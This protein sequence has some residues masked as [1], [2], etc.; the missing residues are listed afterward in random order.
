MRVP[1]Q[2]LELGTP[3]PAATAGTARPA[4]RVV[5]SGR[6]ATGCRTPS[7]LGELRRD[8]AARTRGGSVYRPPVSVPFALTLTK[9]QY[10]DP[11]YVLSRQVWRLLAGPGLH[12][13][14]ETMEVAFDDDVRGHRAPGD[15]AKT[16]RTRHWGVSRSRN[17]RAAS[18]GR[19]CRCVGAE[20]RHRG[21]ALRREMK[22]EMRGFVHVLE[23]AGSAGLEIHKATGLDLAR[24]DLEQR[25]TYVDAAGIVSWLLLPDREAHAFLDID[26]CARD[27][28]GDIDSRGRVR[29]R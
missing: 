29:A 23:R 8:T 5:R 10:T 1:G 16:P 7:G 20:R 17:R 26:P 28:F 9:F 6:P 21:I 3:V 15:V 22:D 11:A 19:A 18:M 12:R 27:R 25:K 2:E 14:A 13:C 24:Q 4:F